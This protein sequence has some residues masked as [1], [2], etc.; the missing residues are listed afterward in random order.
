MPILAFTDD[1]NVY[2]LQPRKDYIE[3]AQKVYVKFNDKSD[4]STLKFEPTK[5]ETESASEKSK[6]QYI[7]RSVSSVNN[8]KC[9]PQH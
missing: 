9:S 3:I 8:T 1:F 6:V 5:T 7:I 2:F 4:I